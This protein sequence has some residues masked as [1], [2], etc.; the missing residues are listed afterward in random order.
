MAYL[1]SP[2]FEYVIPSAL[3]VGGSFAKVFE[4]EVVPEGILMLRSTPTRRQFQ[5][6]R[7]RDYLR[8]RA[9][10]PAQRNSWQEIVQPYPGLQS[11]ISAQTLPTERL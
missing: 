1:T 10:F 11:R 3:P 7:D 4:Y 2:P 8:S 6:Q 5:R 9:L